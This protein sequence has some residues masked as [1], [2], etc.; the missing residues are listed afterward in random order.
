MEKG[1]NT[2]NNFILSRP[3]VSK[4]QVL[5]PLRIYVQAEIALEL[6]NIF[7]AQCG[8]NTAAMPSMPSEIFLEVDGPLI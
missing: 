5:I 2:K 4:N 8:C 1:K 6:R 7:A 3:Q